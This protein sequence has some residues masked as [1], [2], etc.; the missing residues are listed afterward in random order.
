MTSQVVD[1]WESAWRGLTHSLKQMALLDQLGVNSSYFYE[2][3]ISL[4]KINELQ[5]D[6][7]IRLFYLE[8]EKATLYRLNKEYEKALKI[9]EAILPLAE[10]GEQEEYV[11]KWI[12]IIQMDIDVRDGVVTPDNL[13]SYS[14]NCEVIDPGVKSS[15]N[16][17]YTTNSSNQVNSVLK[18]DVVPN[19]VTMISLITIVL[20]DNSTGH[21]EIVT[22]EGKVIKSFEIYDKMYSNSI[23]SNDF[24]KGI[25]AIKVVS[26]NGQTKTTRMI[27][28]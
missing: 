27:I 22:V 26:S 6:N 13:S 18:I 8:I 12:C 9:L 2:T 25:Y 16:A 20:P 19:P 1:I 4:E 17:S 28:Q 10:R 15:F 3:M 7:P 23:S 14:T 5:N 24:P 11:R 21:V